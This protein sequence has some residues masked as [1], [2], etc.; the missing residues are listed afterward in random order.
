M[1][2]RAAPL[3]TM[4]RFVVV[5]GVLGFVLLPPELLYAGSTAL[6]AGLIGLAL[7]L[8]LAALRE[9][10]LNAAGLTGLGAYLFAKE[11]GPGGI[12]HNIEGV[13]I[14]VAVVTGLSILGGAAS[15]VVTGLYF[16]VASL[17]IQV[18]LEKVVF[19]IGSLTGGA[20]G[21]SV[22]QPSFRGWLNTQRAIYLIVGVIVLGLTVVVERLK[23]SRPVRH[24]ILVGYVPDGARAVGVRSWVSKLAVFG[25]SGMLL[26]IAGCLT[27][28]VNGTPP[29]PVVFSVVWSVIYLAIPIASGMREIPA[30]WVVAAV[31]TGLPILLESRQI[32]PNLLS[33]LILLSA[34]LLAQNR[35]NMA[36]R[37][38]RFRAGRPASRTSASGGLAAVPAPAPAPARRTAGSGSAT[39]ALDLRTR[40]ALPLEGRDITVDF[41][42]VR[43]V[44]DVTVRIEPG[45]RVG[46]V[47]ANGA[48]KTTLFNALT[49]YVPLSAGRVFLGDRDITGLASYMRSRAGI[50]RTFQL[51]RL[52]DV[53][54]VGQSL[55]CGHGAAT[56]EALPRA[57]WLLDRFGLTELED[58]PVSAVPFGVRRK[59]ELARAL[60][61][62]PDVLMVDE[63]VSGLEDHEVRELLQVLLELQESE[64]WGMLV[65]EHDLRFIRGVAQHLMVM[66]AGQ[67]LTEG[68]TRAVLAEDRVRRV[69]LGEVVNI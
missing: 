30:I 19:S 57:E 33:G 17:V 6:V 9:L 18:G 13:L 25:V 55:R 52:A 28:F 56:P 1:T 26:G 7:F 43:A 8:P 15:L 63:P 53:L 3:L 61:V 45:Q 12:G 23:T 34:L 50:R 24:A 14:A 44:S 65:I 4:S 58:L 49:G 46:I 38:R 21:R 60:L 20:A 54:T 10:P 42:G 16:A 41:G 31:F 59:L 27:S 64:G 2:L 68:R 37:V 47:G 40:T 36:A 39:R 5:A 69:Y 32:N 66:D 51:P 62:V 22:A 29:P 11:A 48:G 67:V 35:D